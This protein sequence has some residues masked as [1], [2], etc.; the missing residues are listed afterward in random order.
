MLVKAG[1][2]HTLHASS[3]NRRRLGECL[4]TML[5][6]RYVAGTAG[7]LF[8]GLVQLFGSFRLP[9]SRARVQRMSIRVSTKDKAHRAQT[10]FIVLLSF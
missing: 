3:Y 9:K 6:T 2:F 7:L 4:S 8:Q 1:A 10:E 5:T